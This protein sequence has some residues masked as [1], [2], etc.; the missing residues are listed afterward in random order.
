MPEGKCVCQKE[1]MRTDKFYLQVLGS[2][3]KWT[4]NSEVAISGESQLVPFA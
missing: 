2:L 1:N 3:M 4:S